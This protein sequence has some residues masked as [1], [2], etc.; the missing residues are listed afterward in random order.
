M[1]GVSLSLSSSLTDAL[2][3]QNTL[4][5]LADVA[6]ATSPASTNGW[7]QY[8][9][10]AQDGGKWLYFDADT[11]TSGFF[12]ASLYALHER[13]NTLCPASSINTTASSSGSQDWLTLARKWNTQDYQTMV[14]QLTNTHDV[15][16]LSLPLQYE[17][18]LDSTNATVKQAILGMADHLAARFS[19]VV[20]CTRSWDQGGPDDFEVVSDCISSV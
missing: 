14:E 8:T 15:G 19:P 1:A 7:P 2:F 16:F 13:T 17:L 11:W 20:G 4:S 9:E 12:S 3:G 18:A 5:K 10:P 6:S